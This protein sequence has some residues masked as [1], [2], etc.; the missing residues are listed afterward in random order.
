MSY[1]YLTK[2]L[3][4]L[5]SENFNLGDTPYQSEVYCVAILKESFRIHYKY[6]RIKFHL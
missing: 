1:P 6:D 3:E 4:P 5:N 2:G